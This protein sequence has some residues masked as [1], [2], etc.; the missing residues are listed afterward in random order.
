M[1]ARYFRNTGSPVPEYRRAKIIIADA[2]QEPSRNI[3]ITV[4]LLALA[5]REQSEPLIIYLV[6]LL[7]CMRSQEAS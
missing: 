4:H 7:R 2:V 1:Q 5:E 6:R 3:S